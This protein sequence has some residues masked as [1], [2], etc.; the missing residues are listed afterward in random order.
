MRVPSLSKLRLLAI[1]GFLSL[2]P[3]GLLAVG[4]D[5]PLVAGVWKIHVTPDTLSAQ[6]GA[7]D[8]NE[9]IVF[10]NGELQAENFVFYGFDFAAYAMGNPDKNSFTSAMSN[11]TKGN[12][13]WTGAATT[14]GSIS[15]NL[16]WTK[17]D[18]TVWRFTYTGTR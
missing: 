11:A 12:L 9:S 16:V 7:N 5:D 6:N 14:N 18:G 15:G 3:A 13:D 8:F 17:A 2:V 10:V 1:V 4:K